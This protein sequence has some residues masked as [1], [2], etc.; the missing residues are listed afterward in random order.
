[1]L[2]RVPLIANCT[3]TFAPVLGLGTYVILA[4]VNNT[5]TLTE[6]AAFAVLSLFQ[7]QDKPVMSLLHGF[8]DFQT[9]A[10]AFSRVQTY[11]LSDEREDYRTIPAIEH[12]RISGPWE[13]PQKSDSVNVENAVQPNPVD[14][15]GLSPSISSSAVSFEDAAG[16]YSSE[17]MIVKDLT[18]DITRGQTTMVVGPVGSGKSTLLRLLL[19]ELPEVSGSVVS[20]YSTCAFAPQSPWITWGTVRS[21]ILGMSAWDTEWYN[22]VIRA[23]SLNIDF[24][25]LPDGDQT[26]T[27]TRGSRLSGGQQMRVVSFM[28]DFFIIFSFSLSFKTSVCLF[29]CSQLTKTFSH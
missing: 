17:K 18:L 14:A 5:E 6:G 7:L 9:I 10:N 8:E 2:I 3:F 23:C 29:L 22:T 4:K 13:L 21:N 26:R 24:E 19:G 11:I 15:P 12:A 28:S 27:G 25:D 1:M 16:G 20:H